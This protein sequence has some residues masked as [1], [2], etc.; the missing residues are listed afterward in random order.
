MMEILKAVVEDLKI[1]KELK[2]NYLINC[3][4]KQKEQS[5]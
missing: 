3:A 1:N 2:K 5:N 4:Q